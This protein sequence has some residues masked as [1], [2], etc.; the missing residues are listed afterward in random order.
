MIYLMHGVVSRI[1]QGH[2]VFRN[3]LEENTFLQ[4]LVQRKTRLGPLASALQGHCDALTIDDSTVAAAR[5]ARCAASL[6]HDVTLFINPYYTESGTYYFFAALNA[7]L[8]QAPPGRILWAGHDYELG[9]YEEKLAFRKSVKQQLRL[10]STEAARQQFIHECIA[11]VG[12]RKVA[13]P[14][15]LETLAENDLLEL[16]KAGV[17]LSNHGWTHGDV[18]VCSG[19]QLV[20]EIKDAQDWL[21]YRLKIDSDYYAVPFGEALPMPSVGRICEAWFL[22]TI[23]SQEKSADGWVHNRKELKLYTASQCP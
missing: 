22:A 17:S 13:V 23:K 21:R 12:V 7:A 8:D 16:K 6:G 5:A 15:H 1:T 9:S 10:I 2:F 18:W 20:A 11:S 4:W 19:E 3:M 14:A